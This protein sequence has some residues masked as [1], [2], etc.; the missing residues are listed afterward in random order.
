M[1][2]FIGAGG[3]CYADDAETG[4]YS[5][6]F[7]VAR[8]VPFAVKFQ[9]ICTKADRQ[10][11]EKFL[12]DYERSNTNRCL[13]HPSQKYVLHDEFGPWAS[14]EESSFALRSLLMYNSVGSQLC[15]IYTPRG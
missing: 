10:S 11:P 4:T 14:R 9:S 2:T 3:S 5:C 6:H 7:L 13:V 12:D 15:C 1:E 8:R